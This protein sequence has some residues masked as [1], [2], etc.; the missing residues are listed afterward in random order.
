MILVDTSVAIAHPG[1]ADA[2]VELLGDDEAGLPSSRH[3][4]AGASWLDQAATV[5]DLLAKPPL[6]LPAPTT[7]CCG[8]SAWRL[9][10]RG[11]EPS[12]TFWF[13]GSVEARL[14]TRAKRLKAACA[15][16]GAALRKCPELYTVSVAVSNRPG[17]AEVA[18][19]HVHCPI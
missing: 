17:K 10:G 15:E 7:K 12:P 4:G 11:L 18:F 1:A 19:G 5:L 3:R 9:W 16:S 2:T 13:G 14:W 6:K 8:L